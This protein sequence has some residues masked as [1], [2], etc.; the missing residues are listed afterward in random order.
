MIFFKA[1]FITDFNYEYL[2]VFSCKIQLII[3]YLFTPSLESLLWIKFKN[4]QNDDIILQLWFG[5]INLS[6]AAKHSRFEKCVLKTTL[7]KNNQYNN[8]VVFTLAKMLSVILPKKQIKILYLLTINVFM[9]FLHIP[10]AY[11]NKWI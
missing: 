1:W 8:T 7:I 5:E 11:E 10:I 4:T 3:P 2:L 9:H 6:D